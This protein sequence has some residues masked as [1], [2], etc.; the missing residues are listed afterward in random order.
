MGDKEDFKTCALT[1]RSLLYDSFRN[2]LLYAYF[3]V[4]LLKAHTKL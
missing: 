3:T 4:V 2:I 1:S